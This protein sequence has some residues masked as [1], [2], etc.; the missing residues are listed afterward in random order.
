M[1]EM[2][3]L[4]SDVDC[5]SCCNTLQMMHVVLFIKNAHLELLFDHISS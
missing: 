2:T 4:V 5:I 1:L 3:N